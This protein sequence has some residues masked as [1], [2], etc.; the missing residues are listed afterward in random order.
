MAMQITASQPEELVWTDEG[1]FPP[2]KL[3]PGYALKADGKTAVREV[4]AERQPRWAETAKRPKEYGYENKVIVP[5][6]GE[7]RPGAPGGAGAVEPREVVQYGRDASSGPTATMG[8]DPIAGQVLEEEHN[9]HKSGVVYNS[10]IAAGWQDPN[11]GEATDAPLIGEDE[12][13]NLEDVYLNELEYDPSKPAA[14]Q[15]GAQFNYLSQIVYDWIHKRGKTSARPQAAAALDVTPLGVSSSSVVRENVRQAYG[16]YAHQIDNAAEEQR[17]ALAAEVQ[18]ADISRFGLEWAAQLMYSD[19]GML[20]GYLRAEDIPEDVAMAQ[21]ALLE[22]YEKLPP[23]TGSGTIRFLKNLIANPST[24]FTLGSTGVVKNLLAKGGGNALRQSMKQRLLRTA[25]GSSIIGT[26]TSAAGVGADYILQVLEHGGSEEPFVW[27]KRRS[28][29]AGG[30][31]FVVGAGISAGAGP[32]V[33]GAATLVRNIQSGTAPA[34]LSIKDV[35]PG[36][37]AAALEPVTQATDLSPAGFYSAVRRAVDAL[38]QEK[39]GA[40]QMRAMIAKSEGVKAEEMAWIGLDEFLKGRKNV[41]KQEIADFVDANQV[42][43]VQ[44]TKDLDQAAARQESML[45][46]ERRKAGEI[47]DAELLAGE[48]AISERTAQYGPGSYDWAD[49]TLGGGENYREV[50][51]TL[52]QRS[53]PPELQGGAFAKAH[54]YELDKVLTVNTPEG[55]HWQRAIREA[56]QDD[57]QRNFTAGHMNEPNVLAWVRMDDRTGPNG[58]RILF[59]EEMQSDWL[60]KGRELRVAEIERI[61]EKNN[62]TKDEAAKLVP[63]DFGYANP[64]KLARLK[65]QRAKILAKRDDATPD[66]W[67]RLEELLDKRVTDSL[68]ELTPAERDEYLNLIAKREVFD[69]ATGDA[70]KEIDSQIASLVGSVPDAPFKKTWHEMSLRRVIRMAAEEGYDS[71]A[72]TPGKIQAERYDLSKQVNEIAY[73]AFGDETSVILK[74]VK[75][76]SD[77]DLELVLDGEGIIKVTD[78]GAPDDWKGKHIEDVVGKDIAENILTGSKKGR[79][80]GEG[81]QVGGEGMKGFYDKMLKAFAAKFGKKF[82][83]KVGTTKIDMKIDDIVDYSGPLVSDDVR[84]FH[85]LSEEF[86]SGLSFN[87]RQQLGR[88]AEE[89]RTGLVKVW[90]IPITPKMRESVLKKGVPLFSAAGAAT[91]TGA[92]LSEQGTE[93]AS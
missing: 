69:K 8:L 74:G 66:W 77:Q 50:L 10:M 87:E 56:G 79:I 11:I 57:R 31:A 3:P 71:V 76:I 81:L 14:E 2:E 64:E 22:M 78:F 60:Q 26:E 23:F 9:R 41:T 67:P 55:E 86:W 65:G 42:E 73:H 61:A 34:G 44:I 75:G 16:L 18:G 39:G 40:S 33:S 51:L 20:R 89:A 80:S 68:A 91:A 62:I 54:G 28:A 47:T 27:D 90:T 6:A 48:N 21:A 30:L 92:V 72:W 45:L 59:V 12:E 70:L 46:Q 35:T 85:D 83:A 58:E 88:E 15:P 52:P 37:A 82:G 19:I 5:H 7:R 29:A 24:Y 4:M 17:L 1:T 43:V 49:L 13:V 84:V 38:P 53:L 32:V 36:G 25:L 93:P 63:D